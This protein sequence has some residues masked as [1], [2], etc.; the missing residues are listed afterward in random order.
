M[1]SPASGVSL[2]DLPGGSGDAN[3]GPARSAA[4][5][6]NGRTMAWFAHGGSGAKAHIAV[7]AAALLLLGAAG[8]EADPRYDPAAA[9]RISE[10]AVGRPL[11]EYTFTDTLNRKVRLDQFRGKPLVISLVYTSCA[12]VCPV[13]SESLSDAV[14]V[15]QKVLGRDRFSVVTLGFDTRNDTPQRMLAFARSRGLI[16]PNWEFLSGDAA[17]V[18][19]LAEEIG[20]QYFPSPRGFDHVT[21]TTLVDAGGVIF[22]QIYGAI[23]EP[24]RLVE[25]LKDMVLGRGRSVGG[26]AGLVDQV[27][28]FCTFYDPAAGRYRLDYSVILTLGI[29]GVCLGTLGIVLARHLRQR[30]RAQPH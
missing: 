15:A 28:L 13:V 9:L 17:S 7:A 3:D 26:L 24:P 19:R 25:P 8:G 10:A 12:D 6:G 1:L 20:F 18:G 21:Q 16:Q 2:P 23:F 4:R 30:L 22:G 27:R 29:G 5:R 14:G 11:G